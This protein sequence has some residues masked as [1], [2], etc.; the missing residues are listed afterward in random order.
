MSIDKY[1]D[2]EAFFLT[3]EVCV[4]KDKNREAYID[5]KLDHSRIR[6]EEMGP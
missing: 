6:A 3:K 2:R 5:V 1:I 4:S